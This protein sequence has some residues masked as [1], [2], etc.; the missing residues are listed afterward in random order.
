MKKK[1][2]EEEEEEDKRR[3]RRRRRRLDMVH[4]DMAVVA[5]WK[6]IDVKRFH[7]CSLCCFKITASLAELLGLP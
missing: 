2:E 7:C 5:D 6:S 4:P 3:R 1:K